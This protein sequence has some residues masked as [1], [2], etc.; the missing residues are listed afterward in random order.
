LARGSAS[1]NLH[2]G[3]TQDA[4][5]GVVGSKQLDPGDPVLYLQDAPGISRDLR[6]KMLDGL[7]AMNQRSYE[8]VGDPEIQTRIQQYEMA[9]RMQ[10]SVPEL[11]DLSSEPEHIYELYGKDSKVRGTFASSALMARR[12]LE[13]GTRFVQIFHRGWDQHGDF[14]TRPALAVPGWVATG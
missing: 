8:T 1:V 6:R 3:K 4:I 10:A 5:P 9:F 2:F 14:A 7:N 13:R 12:L 11:A